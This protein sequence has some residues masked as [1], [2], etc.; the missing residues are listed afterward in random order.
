VSV[1]LTAV[2]RFDARDLPAYAG[3]QVVGAVLA[4]LALKGVF[5]DA[6]ALPLTG[7]SVN[8][9][10]TFGPDL[11]AGHWDHVWIFLVGPVVGALVG[12][13]AYQAVRADAG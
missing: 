13:L 9:A 4:A 3:A 7:T 2:G 8:P 5:P 6:E 1:A 12:A 11:V 10:R